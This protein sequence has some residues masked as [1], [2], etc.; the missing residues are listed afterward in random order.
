MSMDAI[1]AEEGERDKK[2]SDAMVV[3]GGEDDAIAKIVN[4]VFRPLFPS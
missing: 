3:D 2:P 1:L 4:E